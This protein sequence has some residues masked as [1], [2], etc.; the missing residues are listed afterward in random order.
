MSNRDVSQQGPSPLRPYH[1]M[2]VGELQEGMSVYERTRGGLFV[3]SFSAGLDLSFSVLL[4]AIA[5]DLLVGVVEPSTLRFVTAALYPVGFVFVILGRTELFTEQTTLAIVP[6]LHGR[7]SV[8]AL[9]K[10]WGIVYAGNILGIVILVGLF[11]LMAPVMEIASPAT[12]G[13]I[14]GELLK[15]SAWVILLSAVFAGW[16]MGLLSWLMTAA[17]DTTSQVLII[18]LIATVIGLGHL[19]HS[20]VG[21]GEVFAGALCAQEITFIDAARFVVWATLGNILGG[22]AFALLL[23]YSEGMRGRRLK[24]L[25]AERGEDQSR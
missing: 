5:H 1:E 2:L 16:L 8:R 7:A 23:R 25:G 14:A 12:F 20:I 21:A 24:S 18:W 6:V 19:H 9:G 11:T 3:S 10:L 4:L 17:R 15:H 13:Q 22:V